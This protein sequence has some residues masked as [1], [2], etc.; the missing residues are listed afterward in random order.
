MPVAVYS[1]LGH[2]LSMGWKVSKAPQEGRYYLAKKQMLRRASTKI[3]GESALNSNIPEFG[4]RNIG[5]LKKKKN[6]YH[7]T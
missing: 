5:G 4:G 1:L 2:A 6:T 3:Y 7:F